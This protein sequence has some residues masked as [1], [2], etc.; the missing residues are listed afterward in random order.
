MIL[1]K[2][3]ILKALKRGEL[4]ITPFD[5]K[6]VGA[7]SVDLR[8]DNKFRVFRGKNLIK[9]TENIDYKDFTELVAAQKLVLKP[10]EMVLGITKEKLILPGN[11]CGWLQGRT[12]FARIGLAVHVTTSFVQPGSENQQVLE[13]IN[14]GPNP[15]EIHAQDKICQIVFERTEGKAKEKSKYSYK[16]E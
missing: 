8:L 16:W 4:K 14:V 15:I 12:R 11:M 7:G 1:T 2:N 13:I 5:K 10:G 3:E 9:I 6:A